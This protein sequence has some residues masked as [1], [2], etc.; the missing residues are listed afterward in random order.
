MFLLK[1][2]I[3]LFRAECRI[4]LPRQLGMYA[5]AQVFDTSLPY[6]RI[7]SGRSQCHINAKQLTD[8]PGKSQ[9]KVVQRLYLL[10]IEGTEVIFVVEKEGGVSI[11]S[12]QGIPMAVTPIAMLADAYIPHETM[13][14]IALFCGYG[15]RQRSIRVYYHAAIA[16]GLL[17]VAI[18]SLNVGCACCT[19]QQ[20]GVILY[21]CQ[22]GR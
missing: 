22:V 15:K 13:A 7:L 18:A 6:H 20:F 5:L 17:G 1:H 21:W 10:L 19:L 11:G 12:L 4:G 3:I 2:L 9:I 14:L 16:V 8:K